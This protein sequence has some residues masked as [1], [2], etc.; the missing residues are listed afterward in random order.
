M[1]RRL[2]RRVQRTRKLLRDALLSLILEEGF[3]AISIQDITEKANLGRATFYL[4]YKDK[5]EL[6]SDLM[7]QL[8]VEF[9]NQVPQIAEGKWWMDDTKAITKLFDFAAEH[10]DLYRILLIGKGGISASRQLQSSIAEQIQ[11]SI[12]QEIEE[13]DGK[14]AA[15]MTFIANHFAGS[16]LSTIYWWLESDLPYSSEELA[17][18]VQLVNPMDRE[19]L[20]GIGQTDQGQ[21]PEKTKGKRKKKRKPNYR[22][23]SDDKETAE[24]SPPATHTLQVEAGVDET[25]G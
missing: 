2:D 17:A 8:I 1:A 14:L 19:G 23:N 4:H 7:N 3:D 20:L 22:P 25:E 6:L 16:L 12:Q 9:L 5:E 18:M 10:Y 21:V 24:G 15:P 11:A 13:G